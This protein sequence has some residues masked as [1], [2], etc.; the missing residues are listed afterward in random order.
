MSSTATHS[1]C[2]KVPYH[3]VQSGDRIESPSAAPSGPSPTLSCKQLS[4][5]TWQSGTD[6]KRTRNMS[7]DRT[8]ELDHYHS[9]FL[10]IQ[11]AGY[12]EGCHTLHADATHAC[13]Q[14]K[15]AT[16]RSTNRASNSAPSATCACAATKP[17]PT[18]PNKS[19]DPSQ[20]LHAADQDPPGRAQRQGLSAAQSLSAPAAARIGPARPSSREVGRAAAALHLDW[21]P[22]HPWTPGPAFVSRQSAFGAT[23]ITFTQVA[24]Q[25]SQTM[26]I[27]R[28]PCHLGV[29]WG[30]MMSIVYD[31]RYLHYRT[32][33]ECQDP[34]HLKTTARCQRV[35]PAQPQLHPQLHPPFPDPSS[36]LKVQS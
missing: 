2:H 5:C 8:T 19:M 28:K 12:S 22:S 25:D 31:T 15:S 14:A 33:A 1:K 16:H 36:H 21:W 6:I 29:W 35:S 34:W 3:A 9:L 26:I 27:V 7:E 17:H 32:E 18:P 23:R 11:H 10:L 4:L 24:H 20:Q 13:P 30:P